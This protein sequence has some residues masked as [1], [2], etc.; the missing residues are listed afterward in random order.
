MSAFGGPGRGRVT[1]MAI[2]GSALLGSASALP[3]APPLAIRSASGLEVTVS[4]DGT[5]N[6]TGGAKRWKFRGEVAAGLR[7]LAASAGSDALGAYREAAFSVG[8]PGG[9]RAAIRLYEKVPAAMFV[10]TFETGGANVDPFPTFRAL[11]RVPYHLSWEGAFFPSSFTKLGADAPWV[12]FDGDRD[13]FVLSAAS[14]FVLARTRQGRDGGVECGIDPMIREIPPGYEQ[15]TILF[16]GAGIGTTLDAWGSA[17]TVLSGK[18]RPPADDGPELALL[19]YWTDNGAGYYYKSLPGRTA[20]ETLLEVASRF[21]REGIPLGYVQLDSW[22]YPKGRDGGFLDY[23]AAGPPI[24]DSD[25]RDFQ[26]KLGLPLLV[27]GRWLSRESPIRGEWKTSDRV[28]VD[29]RWWAKIAGELS[30]AGV[31]TFE[32]D[33]LGVRALPERNLSDPEAFLGEMARAFAERSMRVQ[34]CMAFPGDMLESTLYPSVT[35]CRVSGDRFDKSKWAAFFH[36]SLLARA[37]GLRPW[38][39]VFRSR[40]LENLLLALLSSGVVGI[41]DTIGE[42][43]PAAARL[44]ARADGVLVKP[45]LPIV[46]TDETLI[47]EA[48]GRAGPLIATTLSDFGEWKAI[49][50]FAVGA[51]T[52]DEAILTPRDLGIRGPSFLFRV[53]GGEGRRLKETET[54]R[55]RFSG[56]AYWILVPEGPSGVAFLGDEGKL[57]PVGRKRIASVADDGTLRVRVLFA[58][59]EDAVRLHGFARKRPEVEVEAGKA[60]PIEYEPRTGEFRLPVRPASG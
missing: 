5:W 10:S 41:G 31:S 22:W 39:D 14:H 3:A 7:G 24:F 53:D 54:C 42:E 26:K 57:V 58:P 40:E 32:Q 25:L 23:R 36:G 17:L 56:S 21:R 13:A 9:R 6:V 49:Y 60:E 29:R 51:G 27:H 52:K 1:P 50:V 2:L 8:E 45:D 35:T 37:V 34:Y 28:V 30:E 16:F 12:F 43:D 19:G 55:T 47:R 15:R 38:A 20:G 4:P 48:K 44:A 33:W 46:P 18:P 59:G 11:P